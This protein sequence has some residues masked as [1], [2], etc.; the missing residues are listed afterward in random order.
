[1]AKPLPR[2][3]KCTPGDPQDPELPDPGAQE[4]LEATRPLCQSRVAAVAVTLRVDLSEAMGKNF[5]S[6]SKLSVIIIMEQIFE[7]TLGSTLAHS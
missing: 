7:I 4:P 6:R 2:A 3:V 1:M 5:E